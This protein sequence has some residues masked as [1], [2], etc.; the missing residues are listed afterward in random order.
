MNE[1]LINT[2]WKKI[3]NAL[4]SIIK[5]AISNIFILLSGV[6]T[7][8]VIPKIMGITDYG[9]YK[10]FTLYITYSYLFRFGIVEGIYLLYGGKNY[11]D[12]EKKKFR[13]YTKILMSLELVVSLVLVILSLVFLKDEYKYIFLFVS[14]YIWSYNITGYYQ[15]ISQVTGRFNELSFRNI[16]QAIISAVGVIVFWVMYNY[17]NFNLTYKVYTVFYVSVQLLLTI[18]YIYTYRDITFGK[19]EPI[20]SEYKNLFNFIK[21]GFPLLFANLCSTLLLTLDRQFVN[22]LF[23]TDIY[24]IYAFA[25]NLLSLV[26][27]ATSAISTVVYPLLKR[28]TK[29]DLKNLYTKL[30]SIILIFI[31]FA[32]LIYFPLCIF[33][34]YFLPKYV[35]SLEIFIVIFPG[36]AISSVITIIMHNYYKILEENLKY[37]VISFIIL[38]LSTLMN[39][40]TY[41][42]FKNP[43]AISVASIF[44]MI[45]WYIIVDYYICKKHIKMKPLGK[46]FVYMIFMMFAFYC[47][48]FSINNIFVSGISYLIVL[49]I[50]SYLFFRKDLKEFAL[51]FKKKEEE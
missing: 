48:A 1:Q 30:I 21:I 3:Q 17:F 47:I 4:L 40:L 26:T 12:L 38:I 41:I 32:L 51:I 7:G 23:E 33:I 36:L 45:F 42:I 43:I 13:T 34:R 27:V 6:L 5:V 8:F 28:A 9:Y 19:S 15:T 35:A 29:D 20:K 31:S 14:T 46:N 24:A 18:W 44:V 16:L 37:F 11:A 39:V 22:I 50:I 2:K 10:T 49:I 25:Y